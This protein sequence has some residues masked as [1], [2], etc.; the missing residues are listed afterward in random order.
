MAYLDRQNKAIIAGTGTSTSLVA[1]T[2]YP[3]NEGE[4]AYATDTKQLYVGTDYNTGGSFRPVVGYVPYATKTADYT[5]TDN[6][7]LILVDGTYTMTLPT[8]VGIGGR[9][10][11]IKNIG[12]GVVTVATTSSQTID[13]STTLVISGRYDSA[14]LISDNSN[15]YI[16]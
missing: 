7:Y 10:Y 4:I 15:W 1:S 16:N 8:S 11:H 12:T 6:D 2:S 5:L 13:G 3:M 14:K 9:C